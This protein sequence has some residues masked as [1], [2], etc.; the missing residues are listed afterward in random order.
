M[1]KVKPWLIYQLIFFY[2][3]IFPIFNKRPDENIYHN[4]S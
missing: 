4:K 2:R 3:N 1:K